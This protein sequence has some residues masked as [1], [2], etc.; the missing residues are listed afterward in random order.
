MELYLSTSE[1]YIVKK[2]AILKTGW[3]GSSSYVQ[4]ERIMTN[5]DLSDT[6]W[7]N[8]DRAVLLLNDNGIR[9]RKEYKKFKCDNPSVNLLELTELPDFAR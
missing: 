1:D 6:S 9:L 8:R 3:K 2:D 7:K 5:F 4:H